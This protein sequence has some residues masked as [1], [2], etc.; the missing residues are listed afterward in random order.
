MSSAMKTLSSWD[1]VLA[2]PQ[3]CDHLVQL[4]TSDDSLIS[5]VTRF[6]EPGLTKGEAVVAITTAAHWT[7]LAGKLTASG[8]DVAAAESRRQLVVCDAHSTLKTFMVD[9]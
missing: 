8:V 6:I 5:T 9:G 4:Y 2:A 3:P 1:S 7:K